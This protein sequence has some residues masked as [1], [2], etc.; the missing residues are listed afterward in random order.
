MLAEEPEDKTIKSNS[1]SL[2]FGEMTIKPEEIHQNGTPLRKIDGVDLDS[3]LR[4]YIDDSN[5]EDLNP[6]H[7]AEIE[8]IHH[9]SS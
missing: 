7:K 2:T 3:L 4:I 6:I 1:K 8:I 5:K 9:K